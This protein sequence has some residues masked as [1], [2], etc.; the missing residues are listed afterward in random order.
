MKQQYQYYIKNYVSFFK[1]FFIDKIDS[2]KEQ[3]QKKRNKGQIRKCNVFVKIQWHQWIW[4][5]FNKILNDFERMVP[6]QY[7]YIANQNP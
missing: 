1:V 3:T 5:G 7:S 2:Q 6:G 4:N